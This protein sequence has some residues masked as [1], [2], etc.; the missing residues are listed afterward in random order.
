MQEHEQAVHDAHMLSL[1][2]ASD[3]RRLRCHRDEVRDDGGKR[4]EREPV[5]SVLSVHPE[6]GGVDQSVDPG[7]LSRLIPAYRAKLPAPVLW[8][9]DRSDQALRAL[10]LA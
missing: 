9:G 7:E 3:Q 2:R 8:D 4:V 6:R 10:D 1:A 5:E